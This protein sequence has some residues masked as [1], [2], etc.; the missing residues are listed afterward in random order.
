[1][2]RIHNTET[3]DKAGQDVCIKGWVHTRRNMGKIVFLDMRDRSGIVQVVIVPSELS[4]T[5]LETVTQIRSEYVLE[6]FGTVQNRGEKQINAEMDTGRVEIL[7]KNIKILSAAQTTPFEIDNEEKF[8]NEELRLK[9][10]YLDLRK[11]RMKKNM[12]TLLPKLWGL[13]KRP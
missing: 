4:E 13:E 12:N 8:V 1:M 10:R 11:E 6:I 3:K 5:P 9:Y 2:Q 7:A